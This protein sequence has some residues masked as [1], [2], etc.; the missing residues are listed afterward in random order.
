MTFVCLCCSLHLVRVFD[1]R[2]V[3]A[4]A[5]WTV[6]FECTREYRGPVLRRGERIPVAVSGGTSPRDPVLIF[7]FL[8]RV[9]VLRV[10]ELRRV[11]KN[12]K[13]QG[14][15]KR[16]KSKRERKKETKRREKERNKATGERKKTKRDRER[17]GNG[18]FFWE[19]GGNRRFGVFSSYNEIIL[20]KTICDVDQGHHR[21]EVPLKNAFFIRR[22]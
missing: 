3:D 8:P 12:A 18:D 17:E 13:K 21:V 4:T 19:G 20:N 15:G 7:R 9:F 10:R 1:R 22:E 6:V 5:Q 11:S 14:K 2:L 16:Q